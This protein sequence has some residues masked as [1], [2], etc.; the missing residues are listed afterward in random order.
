MR[1]HLVKLDRTLNRL[2][3][4]RSPAQNQCY[5]QL[6]LYVDRAGNCPENSQQ[7]SECVDDVSVMR[8]A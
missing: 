8:C 6:S 7:V 4:A 1:E 5:V 2:Y 3:L